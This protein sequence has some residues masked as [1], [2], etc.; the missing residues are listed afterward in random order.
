MNIWILT[1]DRGCVLALNPN[2]MTG[3]SGWIG[4]TV[5]A[6]GLSVDSDL[7]DQNGVALYKLIDGAAVPRD[8]AERQGDWGGVES[9]ALPIEERVDVLEEDTAT[10]SDAVNIL[11]GVDGNA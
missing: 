1:D 10:L 7:H 8:L 2:D 6:L 4:S 9:P 11:L 3:N 5:E